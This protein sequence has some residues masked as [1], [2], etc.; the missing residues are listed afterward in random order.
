MDM[1]NVTEAAKILDYSREGLRR[2]CRAG[3]IP[4]AVKIGGKWFVLKDKM[5]EGAVSAR[6]VGG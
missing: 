1:L 4:G 2:A 6:E 3:R 5:V